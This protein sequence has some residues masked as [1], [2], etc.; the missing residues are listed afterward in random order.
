[1]APARVVRALHSPLPITLRTPPSPTQITSPALLNVCRIDAHPTN[2]YLPTTTCLL[3]RRTSS[4]GRGR[5]KKPSVNV[6]LCH[7]L[8]PRA[9]Q[10]TSIH[11]E[12]PHA[13]LFFFPF[14]TILFSNETPISNKRGQSR[15]TRCW[16]YPTLPL[17]CKRREG[18]EGGREKKKIHACFRPFLRPIP[19]RHLDKASHQRPS[20]SNPIFAASPGHSISPMS[21]GPAVKPRLSCTA[22]T[23]LPRGTL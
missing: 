20:P 1:M 5:R 8:L 7:T 12:T 18:G 15:E 9:Y 23:F 13:C 19:S 3:P 2:Y 14:T 22:S 21:L 4:S 17:G 11:F 16:G 10:I 6:S